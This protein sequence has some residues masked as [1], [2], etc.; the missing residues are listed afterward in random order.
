MMSVKVLALGS[1]WW[2][3]FGHDAKDPHRYTRRAAY[4]NSAGVRCGQKIN[5]HWLLPGLIRFNGVSDFDPHFPSRAIGET[6][7]CSNLE[8]VCGGNRILFVRRAPKGTVPDRYLVVVS[9]ERFGALDFANS[10]WKSEFA[11]P[12]S[13]SQLRASQEAMLLMSD[14][15]SLCTRLGVWQLRVRSGLPNGAA[16]ELVD[17]PLL[18]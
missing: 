5:R 7:W 9:G 15:D 17:G 2:M 13:I 14:G 6:F 3:R 8:F 18:P 1:N 16:L 4:Y 12:I 10:S 11:E